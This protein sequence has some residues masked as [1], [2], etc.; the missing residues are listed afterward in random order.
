[1]LTC[2]NCCDIRWHN[3]LNPAIKKVSWSPDEDQLIIAL[4]AKLGNAWAKIADQLDGRTDNAVKNRWHS[5]LLKSSTSRSKRGAPYKPRRAPAS[6]PPRAKKA[7][8]RAVAS[9]VSSPT[10][11]DDL[12]PG[13]GDPQEEAT[14]Q[15]L[16][17]PQSASVKVETSDEVKRQPSFHELLAGHTF[18]MEGAI[19]V[20]REAVQPYQMAEDMSDTSSYS[21]LTKL[22]LSTERMDDDD[23]VNG[24]VLEP[25]PFTVPTMD[26][27]RLLFHALW[28]GESADSLDMM[29]ETEV[30]SA[31][32]DQ[33]EPSSALCVAVQGDTLGSQATQLAISDACAHFYGGG[34]WFP[35]QQ[36]GDAGGFVTEFEGDILL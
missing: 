30:P 36:P 23:H 4:Q 15:P 11:V 16:L 22:L 7:V 28:K 25:L 18:G 2:C 21:P 27:D 32:V 1:M 29:V 9:S 20:K 19:E 31:L 35:S 10:A 12:V 8:S 13:F 34:N 17:E 26:D 33:H 3:Q 5:S 6:R 14:G 24:N